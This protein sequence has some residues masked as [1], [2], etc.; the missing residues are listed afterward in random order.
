MESNSNCEYSSKPMDE[1]V[2]NTLGV[3]EDTVF[4]AEVTGP[5]R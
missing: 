3:V 4:I 5:G 2:D 1:E